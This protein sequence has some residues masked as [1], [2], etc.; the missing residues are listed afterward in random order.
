MLVYFFLSTTSNEATKVQ[1]KSDH[2]NVGKRNIHLEG[3]RILRSTVQFRL[4]FDTFCAGTSELNRVTGP[5]K[6]EKGDRKYLYL[7]V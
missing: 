4:M 6:A 5:I 3:M 2:L 7:F 1:T